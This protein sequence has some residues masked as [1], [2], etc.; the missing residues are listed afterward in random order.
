MRPGDAIWLD[1]VVFAAAGY[2]HPEKDTGFFGGLLGITLSF[3]ALRPDAQP[4][5][6][7]A[8]LLAAVV[9]CYLIARAIRDRLFARAGRHVVVLTARPDAFFFSP[10]PPSS[11][12]PSRGFRV[13]DARAS[14]HFVHFPD[15]AAAEAAANAINALIRR[16][17]VLAQKVRA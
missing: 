13:R 16:G 11:G 12:D 9:G 3:G 4:G 10:S 5:M 8:C 2:A 7:A 17:N 1:A 15:S 14:V 6:V